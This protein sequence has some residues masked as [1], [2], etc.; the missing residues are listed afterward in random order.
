M[1]FGTYDLVL[2]SIVIVMMPLIIWANLRTRGL[3]SPL[4]QYIWREFPNLMRTSLVILAL[5]T[6]FSA[7][8]LMRHFGLMSEDLA[9]LVLPAVGVPF[10]VASIALIWI[11]VRAVLKVLRTRN[12]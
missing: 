5:L 10:L 9:E 12:A 4:N 3:Q 1:Q 2:N 11:A 8:S 7:V 6:V